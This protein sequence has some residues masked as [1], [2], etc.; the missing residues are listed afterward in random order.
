MPVRVGEGRGHR[1][2]GGDHLT[3]PQPPATGQQVG[4]AAAGQQL[5]DQGDPGLSP[6]PWLVDHLEE[7]DQVRMVELT[8][9]RRLTRLPRGVARDQHLHRDRRAAPPRHRPP[10]LAGA[11]TAE[12]RL[13]RVAGHH[14]GAASRGS[15]A[16]LVDMGRR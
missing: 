6:A 2:D 5:E 4:Q 7:P 1:G 10:D 8:Q 13:Q 12:P 15:G 14:R 16:G 11:A 3:R 9:Q